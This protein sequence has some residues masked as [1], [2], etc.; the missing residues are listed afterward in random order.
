MQLC[1]SINTK[2]EKK[3]DYLSRKLPVLQLI[4]CH[5]RELMRVLPQTIIWMSVNLHETTHY[6]KIKVSEC[7]DSSSSKLLLGQTSLL[8]MTDAIQLCAY[9][10]QPALF[11]SRL[12]FH[13]LL[14]NN[15]SHPHIMSF[16]KASKNILLPSHV[17][18]KTIY[19]HISFQTWL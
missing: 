8:A 16:I 14:P 9:L 7:F 5:L 12:Q 3:I 15:K 10:E 18:H 17:I 1:S 4:T 2:E 13:C 6:V 11:P 19:S